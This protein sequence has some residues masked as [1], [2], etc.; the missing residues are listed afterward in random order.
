MTKQYRQYKA[1]GHM[2]GV[3]NRIADPQWIPLAAM[4]TDKQDGIVGTGLFNG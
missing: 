1:T 4:T 2:V 3:N